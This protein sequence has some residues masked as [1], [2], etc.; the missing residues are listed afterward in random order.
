MTKS[1][2]AAQSVLGEGS[3]V[4]SLRAAS[5]AKSFAFMEL[6]DVAEELL[7]F[8]LSMAE[9]NGSNGFLVHPSLSSQGHQASSLSTLRISNPQAGLGIPTR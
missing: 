1:G 9:E 5:R 4:F 2:L 6:V 8:G 7:A 3:Y